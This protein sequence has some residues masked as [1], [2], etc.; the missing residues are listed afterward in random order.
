M[1]SETR[2]KRDS[3][4]ERLGRGEAG[5]LDELCRLYGST[6]T[7]IARRKL[8]KK[9][10]AR[11]ETDDIAQEAMVEVLRAA[12]HERFESEEAFLRW[13]RSVVDHRIL[14]EARRW[15]AGCRRADREVFMPTDWD[16]ED[17]QAE[18]PSQ[19]A[20]RCETME[21]VSMALARLSR[22]DR[23]VIVSRLILKLPWEKVA[24]SIGGSKEAAQ[25]R[26]IRARR[27]LSALLEGDTG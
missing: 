17:P 16:A 5:S 24:R 4:F 25:M 14:Q 23:E 20:Q 26:F 19:V 3:L 9:L 8:W 22:D 13:V 27:R 6:V 15:H 12:P 2:A 11:V 18:R 10:R 1:D 21:S 7:S